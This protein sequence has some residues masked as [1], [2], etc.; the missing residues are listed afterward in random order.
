MNYQYMVKQSAILAAKKIT[1][2]WN[3]SC[4]PWWLVAGSILA[5]G[6]GFG[7]LKIKLENIEHEIKKDMIGKYGIQNI[8]NKQVKMIENIGYAKQEKVIENIRTNKQG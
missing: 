4:H 2:L 8:G 5:Y 7:H 1:N 6:H 3:Q